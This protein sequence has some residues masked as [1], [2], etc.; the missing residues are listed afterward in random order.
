MPSTSTSGDGEESIRRNVKPEPTFKEEDEHP[1]DLTADLKDQLL[2]QAMPKAHPDR[3]DHKPSPASL[4][5]REEHEEVE[6]QPTTNPW[7]TTQA[8]VRFRQSA[9]RVAKEYLDAQDIKMKK[10]KKRKRIVRDQEV[11]R[12]GVRD[13]KK[14][15]VRRKRIEGADE[16]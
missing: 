12:R 16:Q 6:T 1:I 8:L 9:E 3:T 13:G 10:G 15:D 7:N 2:R 4:I 14:I 5:N 11:Y